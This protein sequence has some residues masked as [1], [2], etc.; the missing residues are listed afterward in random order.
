MI[1]RVTKEYVIVPNKHDQ[2]RHLGCTDE[3]QFWN[4]YGSPTCYDTNDKCWNCKK[5]TPKKV[6]FIFNLWKWKNTK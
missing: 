3:A 5:K 1:I 6:L 2:L 4:M